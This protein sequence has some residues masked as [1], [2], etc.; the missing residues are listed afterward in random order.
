MNNLGRV[1]HTLPLA[2]KKMGCT[3]EDILHFGATNRLEICAYIDG[4]E[5]RYDYCTFNVFFDNEDSEN[6]FSKTINKYNSI[7]TDMYEI[8]LFNYNDEFC[9]D[10]ERMVIEGLYANHM[11][12]FFAIPSEFLVEVELSSACEIINL[13]PRYLYTPKGYGNYIRL[14]NIEG[15]SIPENRLVIFDREISDFNYERKPKY[16]GGERESPK[17]AAKR[18]EVIYSLIKLI[19]EMGDVDLDTESLPK[20]ADLIDSI[21]ASRGIEFP[22][23]HWQTWQ[24]YLGRES[25][26]KRKK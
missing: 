15:L 18:N 2:A 20:I 1:Y 19:P 8:S 7:F 12:G 24:K 11:K 25:Q 14:D 4:V 21:A 26:Q 9:V 13:S 3:V 16:A 17:T 6:S 22:K 10:D 5:E 23:T